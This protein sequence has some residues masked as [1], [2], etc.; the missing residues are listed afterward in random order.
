MT[1]GGPDPSRRSNRK[2]TVRDG[3]GQG[4]RK[5]RPKRGGKNKPDLT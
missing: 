1:A 3:G 5:A 4:I 2:D